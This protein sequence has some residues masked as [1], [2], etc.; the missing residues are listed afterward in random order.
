MRTPFAGERRSVGHCCDHCPKA[1]R[2][3]K[4]AEDERRGRLGRGF[5]HGTRQEARLENKVALTRDRLAPWARLGHTRHRHS[6]V[7]HLHLHFL[8]GGGPEALRP[9]WI[10]SRYATLFK[11][12]LSPIPSPRTPSPPDTTAL[13]C[14]QAITPQPALVSFCSSH[15]L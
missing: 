2:E 9:L 13:T 12:L 1:A 14:S 4:S 5:Q 11:V 15:S 3:R 10:G 8:N 7:I 6:R